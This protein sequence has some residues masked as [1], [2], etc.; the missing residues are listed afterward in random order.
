MT[1][2]D[3]PEVNL[4]QMDAHPEHDPVLEALREEFK[5]LEHERKAKAFRS[6][7]EAQQPYS[8]KIT[9]AIAKAFLAVEALNGEMTT[10][11]GDHSF[12]SVYKRILFVGYRR[13]LLG[14]LSCLM[15]GAR[16]ASYIACSRARYSSQP[17]YLAGPELSIFKHR[18]R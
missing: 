13:K 10:L 16:V 5:R 2:D 9:V 7:Q 6:N 3:K 15:L 11:C 14:Y 18:F 12:K 4:T 8:D 17:I 1:D